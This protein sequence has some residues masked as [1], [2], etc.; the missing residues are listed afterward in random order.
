MIVSR[1][2]FDWRQKYARCT[3]LPV[4]LCTKKIP[5]VHAIRPASGEPES[6]GLKPEREEE[7]LML[8][9]SSMDPLYKLTVQEKVSWS[10]GGA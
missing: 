3:P 10:K 5:V 8:K 6:R 2:T 1:N 4:T 9:L 7:A